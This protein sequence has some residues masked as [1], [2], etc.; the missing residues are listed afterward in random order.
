MKGEIEIV[1]DARGH[2][3]PVPSLRWRRAIERAAPGQLVRLIADDPMAV[4]DAPHL[5][6][7]LGL[8]LLETSRDGATAAFL[9]RASCELDGS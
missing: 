7:E 4:I 3:C 1:V 9:T 6:A 2:R 8:P 5:L